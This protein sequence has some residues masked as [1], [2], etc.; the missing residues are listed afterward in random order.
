[1]RRA[2]I[3]LALI[4]SP[5]TARVVRFEITNRTDLANGRYERVAGKVHFALDP[6]NPHNRAIVDLD[7]APRNQAGE[8]EFSADVVI[9]RPKHGSEATFIDIVNRGGGS[10]LDPDRQS[11]FVLRHGFSV[12]AVGWQ[13]DVRPDPQLLHLDAPVAAGVTGKVRADFVVPETTSDHSLGH[14]IVG[15]I[16]GTGYAV[17]DVKDR[18]AVLT[19]RDAQ[20][21]ERRTIPRKSWRF[22]NPT[23]IHLDSGFVPGRIYEVIY[24]GK[25]PAVVG[26]GLAAVRDFVSYLKYGDAG[27]ARAQRVYGFGI[28]QSGRF[29]RHFVYQGFNADEEGRQVFDGTIPVVAGAGRGNFNHRFAQPSRDAQ[30]L[31]P[32]FYAVDIPPFTDDEILAP[33]AADKV[34][35]KIMYVN[36]SYEFWSR[37]ESLTYTTPDAQREVPLP[38]NVRLY[39]IAGMSHIGGPFPPAKPSNLELLGQN[40]MNPSSYWPV[41]HAVFLNM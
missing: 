13:F 6:A 15:N 21:A 27:F 8:V 38:P 25:D 35:P 9:V 7:R 23:T 36:T 34:L 17:S 18:T 3:L 16:G 33:A 11:D 40:Q 5:L 14:V 1:M 30:A 28:S 19:E 37:G 41:L 31:S 32:L 12:A 24:T 2:L 39:T 20:L 4:A 29:L 26:T 22:T 10:I